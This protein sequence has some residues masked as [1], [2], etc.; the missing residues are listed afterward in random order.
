MHMHA[1]ASMPTHM[2]TA[3]CKHLNYSVS[4]LT[5]SLL[6][7]QC[8]ASNDSQLSFIV[9]L[10]HVSTAKKCIMSVMWTQTS[11]HTHK[12]SVSSTSTAGTIEFSFLY[13]M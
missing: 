12:L 1:H 2:Q 8:T 9:P 13:L 3:T 4:P 5:D 10:P 11:T 7:L 6:N